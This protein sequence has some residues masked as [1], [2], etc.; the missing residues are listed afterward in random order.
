MII[1]ESLVS[2]FFSVIAVLICARFLLLVFPKN[3]SMAAM[4]LVH[5]EIAQSN[6]RNEK[7]KIKTTH[8]FNQIGW[9]E[10]I[11]VKKENQ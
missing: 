8:S 9:L 4:L 2:I 11:H 5:K 7:E 6:I 3:S 1:L 10:I